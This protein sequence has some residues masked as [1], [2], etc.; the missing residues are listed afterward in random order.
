MVEN[1]VHVSSCR[2]ITDCETAI[3][4]AFSEVF[5]QTIPSISYLYCRTHYVRTITQ[6]LK[7]KNNLNPMFLDPMHQNFDRNFFDAVEA[8]KILQFVPLG[9]ELRIITKLSQINP[10]QNYEGFFDFMIKKFSRTDAH[11]LN[12]HQEYQNCQMFLDCS[13]NIQECFNRQI[14]ARIR[15]HTKS[16]KFLKLFQMMRGFLSDY[17]SELKVLDVN[18]SFYKR[19][20]QTKINHL[21]RFKFVKKFT[22]TSNFSVEKNPETYPKIL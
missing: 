6:F 2:L 14:N 17:Y 13:N 4:N 5:D 7:D 1:E 20:D 21:K 10:N 12:W 11:R 15:S 18:C 16:Q 22:S 9:T 3:G 8:C 19:E